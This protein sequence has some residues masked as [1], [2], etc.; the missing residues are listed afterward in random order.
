MLVSFNMLVLLH[1][2]VI[3]K[4]FFIA[5]DKELLF[6]LDDEKMLRQFL[7]PCKYYPKSAYEKVR[8]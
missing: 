3:Y 5:D 6:P 8:T 2:E 4:H 7:R 1:Y